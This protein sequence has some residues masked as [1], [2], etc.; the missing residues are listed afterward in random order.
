MTPSPSICGIG[1]VTPP[2]V[3]LV[4]VELHSLGLRVS[5]SSLVALIGVELHSLG[6]GS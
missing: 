6:L 5:L 1:G 2:I 4:R 3:P